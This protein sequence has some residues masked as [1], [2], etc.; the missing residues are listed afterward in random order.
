M[1][2]TILIALGAAVALVTAAAA[3][4]AFSASGVSATTATFSTTK[5]EHLRTGSCTGAD[6]KAFTVTSGHYT[7]TADFANPAADFDGPLTI[8]ARTVYSTTDGLGWAEAPFKV[9]KSPASP[10]GPFRGPLKATQ[11]SAG[12]RPTPRGAQ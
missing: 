8:D 6:S 10:T 1:R 7:G 2:K 11:P 9:P 3:F 5:V 12:S 4:A